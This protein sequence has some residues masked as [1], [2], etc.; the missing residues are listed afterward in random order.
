MGWK[1]LPFIISVVFLVDMNIY[2]R[3]DQSLSIHLNS[4]FIKFGSTS[5]EWV[6][7]FYFRLSFQPNTW[8][9]APSTICNLLESSLLEV[10]WWVMILKV[11]IGCSC[12]PACEPNRDKWS[13]TKYLVS[14]IVY[15]FSNCSASVATLVYDIC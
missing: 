14:P 1:L 3:I 2:L 8:G 11:I 13:R 7:V 5:F 6:N 9:R 12:Y 15:I 10:L 4:W